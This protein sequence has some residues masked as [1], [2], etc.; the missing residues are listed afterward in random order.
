MP[1]LRFKY[2]YSPSAVIPG[3]LLLIS[4][5]G[6]RAM[7]QTDSI[8]LPKDDFTL[9]EL[10]VKAKGTSKQTFNAPNTEL[11]TAVELSRA[12]CCN[13]GESFSTNPSVDVNYSD[14]AT[15][16][17]QIRLLGLSGSYVQMLTENVPGFRGVSSP[18][19]LDFIP[20]AWIQSIQVSKGASSV[21]NGFESITGQIN[22]ELLKPQLQPSLKVNAY[23][24]SDGKLELNGMGNLHFGDKWSG[25]LLVHGANSFWTHD[26]NDDGFVD[27]PKIQRLSL[28][29]R[30]AYMGTNYVF[31]ISAKGLLEKRRSG[32][33]GSH[34]AHLDNPYVIDIFSKRLELFTKN[35]FIIDKES[36]AN[37][38][39]ILSGNIHDLDAGYG[40]K[41]YDAL[42]YDAYA[43]LMFERKW[44]EI[45]ALSIGLNFQYDNYRQHFRLLQQPAGEALRD[46]THE[47][48]SGLYGQYTLNLE[49]KLILMGGL[50]F[51]YSSLYRGFVTPRLHIRYNPVE[52]WSFHASV[53]TGARSPHPLAEFNYLLAS[54]RQ[55]ELP[56]KLRMEHGFNT[57]AGF[58]WNSLIHDLP[59]SFSAEY[60]YTRFSNQLTADLD[61]PHKI[62][63]STDSKAYSHNVQAEL[64]FDPL[65]DL[66]VT[67]AYRLTDVKVNYGA[68]YVRK[69]LTS[70]HRGL[71]TASYKPFMGKWQFDATLS[72]NGGGV[73]PRSYALADGS[74]SWKDNYP[75]FCRL[76]LQVTRYFRHWSV[77]AGGE[78]LTNFRQKNPIVSAGDPW[79]PD[80]DATM[81]WGPLTGAMFYVGFRYN[82]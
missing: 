77:Y 75:A 65:E 42:Q 24:D 50:R 33:I 67:A 59:V 7:A 71:F 49:E 53:G 19:A 80:F 52:S 45:H 56:E 26:G 68:G 79:S 54:S 74:M 16:A 47:A 70:L 11:I 18:Y 48:V 72:V 60:Y 38:A 37:I 5:L 57:G 2:L 58:T 55:W 10:V 64:T 76:N 39:L 43:S 12:A 28:V 14:A 66:S 61:S 29:N 41:F 8:P 20:G 4:F 22:V 36:D 21:K 62:I 1:F 17:K 6:N 46:Y 30:W 40:Y 32:Q 23:F 81:V 82:L 31:Q 25:G 73:M 51:D 69:P 78:N 3:L 15:G 63:I 13:L 35:A 44:S 27:M 34:A 9:D